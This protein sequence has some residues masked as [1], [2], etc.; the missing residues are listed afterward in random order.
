MV[1]VR[2]HKCGYIWEYRGRLRLATCPNCNAKVDTSRNRV[3]E[4]R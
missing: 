3:E 2:C 4:G 1:R